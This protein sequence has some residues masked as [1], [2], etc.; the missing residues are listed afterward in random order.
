MTSAAGSFPTTDWGLLGNLRAQS[1]EA[2][3]ASLDILIRRYW[4]PVYFFLRTSGRNDEQ[5][6]DLTQA[7]F[8]DW[9]ERDAFQ[10][11]DPAKGR[12]RTFL[13][14]CLK[15]F[16]ANVHR[17]EYAAKRRPEGGVASLD[18]MMASEVIHYEPADH[19][20]PE[21]LFNRAWAIAVLTHVL[22][23]LNQ[24]FNEKGQQAHADILQSRLVDPI[25]NGIPPVPAE[26]LAAKYE[27]ST[28]QVFNLLETAKRAYR[29]MIRD[30]VSLY[31]V[32]SAEI[33]EEIND[34]F[35]ILGESA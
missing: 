8:L 7:F 13:L 4:K 29:Q 5:A 17:A 35:R 14:T 10:W 15:R 12:F 21:S 2:R 23:R 30:E 34:L 32:N 31:A 28:K 3:R 19:Q 18:E 16:A 9:L 33:S 25:L 11:A 27:I 1:S 24:Q 20:T 6:K 22:E 26:E